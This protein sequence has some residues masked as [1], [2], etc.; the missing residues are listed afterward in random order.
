MVKY[1]IIPRRSL[2]N[3]NMPLVKSHISTNIQKVQQHLSD[4][5]LLPQD[6]DELVAVFS[7][8]ND[9]DLGPIVKLFAEDSSWIYKISKNYKAKQEH[10]K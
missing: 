5:N 6:R 8:A 2:K 10:Q 9:E 1:L 7:K 4:S 3:K